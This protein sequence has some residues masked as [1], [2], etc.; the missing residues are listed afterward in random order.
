M[1]FIFVDFVWD[2]LSLWMQI[3]LWHW[4]VATTFIYTKSWSINAPDD[5]YTHTMPWYIQKLNVIGSSRDDERFK[6]IPKI[7]EKKRFC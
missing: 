1:Y 5:Q 2:V 3:L 4:L 7:I 6:Q